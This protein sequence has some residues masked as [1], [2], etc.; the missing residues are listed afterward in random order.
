MLLKNFRK[1]LFFWRGGGSYTGSSTVLLK[2]NINQFLVSAQT[3]YSTLSSRF[4]FLANKAPSSKQSPVIPKK[5][6]HK[7]QKTL[8]NQYVTRIRNPENSG[9][10][11]I[12]LGHFPSL[13]KYFPFPSKARLC[14]RQSLRN[15][16]AD[17]ANHGT[18]KARLPN[19]IKRGRAPHPRKSSA[20]AFFLEDSP[21]HGPFECLHAKLRAHLFVPPFA[22]SKAFRPFAIV[23]R[24][25]RAY[26]N[27]S[28]GT[29]TAS[30]AGLL[31]HRFR[32]FARSEGEKFA[33]SKKC[34][35]DKPFACH[36][37]P[38]DHRAIST[39]CA[40]LPRIPEIPSRRLAATKVDR[41]HISRGT[42][43]SAFFMARA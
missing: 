33:F 40:M 9:G 10:K 3:A 26:A 42:V 23:C 22:L 25:I 18:E 15:R 32:Y 35:I 27:H 21:H 14:R 12:E 13:Q 7:A 41:K 31:F 36:A 17:N 4:F 34:R 2:V 6:F 20:W 29:D 11:D 16:V 30:F 1:L 5:Q 43:C 37:Q 38:H 24:L 39:S 19:N 28:L 8:S